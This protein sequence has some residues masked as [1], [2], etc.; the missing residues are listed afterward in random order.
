MSDRPAVE[1]RTVL[2]L[3]GKTATGIEVPPDLV[4]ALGH[5]RKPPV[6]VTLKGHTYRSTVAFMG[7]KYL[8]GVSAENRAAASVA[9][10][11]EIDVRLELDDAPREVDV[12]EDLAAALAA[13]PAAAAA[14]A[15]LSF[16]RRKEHAL[17]VSSAKGDDTRRRRLAK[18][19]ETLRA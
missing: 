18:V 17:S 10:G 9:A 2:R 15:R 7:G 4:E 16:T 8:V 13:D 19:L 12:P 3:H 11:D 14:F 5:G 6:A 1:F